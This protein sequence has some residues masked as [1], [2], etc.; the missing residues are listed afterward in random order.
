MRLTGENDMETT[1]N[2]RVGDRFWKYADQKPEDR[3]GCFVQEIIDDTHMRMNDRGDFLGF[4]IVNDIHDLVI[5][6][7]IHDLVISG[8]DTIDDPRYSEK[9]MTSTEGV[10]LGDQFWK[11]REQQ[12]HQRT[13]CYVIKI[14][15]ERTLRVCDSPNG[16]GFCTDTDISRLIPG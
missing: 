15:D 2:V 5:S 8:D 7:D 3:T 11:Y 13:N 12:A 1:L 4:S 14:I 16:I 6:G 10:C 9:G